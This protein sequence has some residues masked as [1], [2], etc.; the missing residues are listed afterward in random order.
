M[1]VGRT[2]DVAAA[3]LLTLDP[4]AARSVGSHGMSFDAKRFTNCCRRSIAC[5]T[6]SKASR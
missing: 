2:D 4:G 1:T 3:E 6:P 5:A